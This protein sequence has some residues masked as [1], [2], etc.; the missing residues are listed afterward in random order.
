VEVSTQPAR[1]LTVCGSN[2][3]T[4]LPSDPYGEA[5]LLLFRFTSLIHHLASPCSTLSFHQTSRQVYLFVVSA[6]L[7]G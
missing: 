6:L 2:E 4:T 3:L 1:M 7:D 5:L